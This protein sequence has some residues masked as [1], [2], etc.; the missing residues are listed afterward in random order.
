MNSLSLS[1]CFPSSQPRLHSSSEE[2]GLNDERSLTVRRFQ[3]SENGQSQVARRQSTPEQGNKAEHTSPDFLSASV[4]SPGI[5]SHAS[6][7][8]EHK[9]SVLNYLN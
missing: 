8:G 1:F 7:P 6:D 3:N 9:D 2:I 4:S 5:L